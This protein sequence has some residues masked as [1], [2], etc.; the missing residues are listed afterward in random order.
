MPPN[1]ASVPA[2]QPRFLVPFSPAGSVGSIPATDRGAEPRPGEVSLAHNGVLFLDEIAEFDRRALK[3]LRQPL[4]EG[5][6]NIARAAGIATFP[7]P[8]W[9]PP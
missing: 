1:V 8:C 6:V 2:E 4:E 9:L 7:A 5:S 3:V